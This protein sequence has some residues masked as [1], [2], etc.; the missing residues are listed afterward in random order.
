MTP[1][2][3]WRAQLKSWAL[4][5]ELLDAVEDSPYQWPA[6]LWKRRAAVARRE[7]ETPT[8]RVVRSL[9]PAGGSLLDVGAGAGRASLPLAAE[10]FRVTGVEKNPGMVEA[11]RE[12]AAALGLDALAVESAWPDA[13]VPV[14]DVTMCANVVYDVQDIEPFLRAMVG[15]ARCGVVVELTAGHPWSN[16]T[17]YYR[18]LHRLERPTGPTYL[19]FVAVVADLVEEKIEVDVWTRPG[20]VWYQSWDEVLE[21]YGRRLVLPRS[22]WQELRSLLAPDVAEDEGRLLVGSPERQ[23][24]TVWWRS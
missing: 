21:F 7:E 5:A 17:P 23:L 22:R 18:V 13:D 11:F 2:E 4:P 10:G 3:R 8:T 1:A 6:S 16:L 12:E 9:L 19:D 14:H 20:R 24:V 15:H